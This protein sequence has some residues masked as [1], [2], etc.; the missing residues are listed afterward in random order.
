MDEGLC[1][2]DEAEVP[3]A[4]DVAVLAPVLVVVALGVVEGDA[5]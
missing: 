2:T 4:D 5:P 3:D 1:A